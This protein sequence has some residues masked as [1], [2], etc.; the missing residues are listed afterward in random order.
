MNQNICQF[1]GKLCK[2]KLSL[3]AH[4]HLCKLNP[5]RRDLSGKNNPRYGKT[6]PNKLSEETYFK[7][8]NGDTINKTIK[9]IKEY[10]L[11]HTECEICGSK[12]TL[13][14]D[15]DHKTK[16][17]RGILCQSCNRSL[18]WYD[19]YHNEIENYLVNCKNK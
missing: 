19:K 7:C 14:V 6:P 1:C 16:Q 3:V 18:G 9:E 15:H 13:C 10:K 8:R 5:N 11:I 4:E 17:F 2:N 12:V